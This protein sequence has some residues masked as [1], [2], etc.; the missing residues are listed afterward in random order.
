MT[1]GEYALLTAR[2]LREREEYEQW[3]RYKNT[4]K[5]RKSSRE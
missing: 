1:Q 4:T 3:L 2:N 5:S